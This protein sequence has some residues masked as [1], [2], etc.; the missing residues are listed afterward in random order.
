MTTFVIIKLLLHYN[1]YFFLAFI[2]SIAIISSI[3]LAF[4]SLPYTLKGSTVVARRISIFQFYTGRMVQIRSSNRNYVLFCIKKEPDAS[5]SMYFSVFFIFLPSFTLII[6]SHLK[7]KVCNDLLFYSN[8]CT[9]VHT[10]L[11]AI[12]LLY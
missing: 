5:G 8:L 1:Y 11:V 2:L 12:F 3:N 7:T 10:S 4:F 6:F 9:P